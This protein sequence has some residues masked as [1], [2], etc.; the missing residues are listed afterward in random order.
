MLHGSMSQSA[1]SPQS[2]CRDRRGK[3]CSV[4]V[5]SYSTAAVGRRRHKSSFCIRPQDRR[6]PHCLATG[7]RHSRRRSLFVGSTVHCPQTISSPDQ[8]PFGFPCS[9]KPWTHKPGPSQ[10]AWLLASPSWPA[11]PPLA[12]WVE[13]FQA[14]GADSRK[15]G[16]AVHPPLLNKACCRSKDK[17]PSPSHPSSKTSSVGKAW[18]CGS[19]QHS[20]W[21]SYRRNEGAGCRTRCLPT[22]MCTPF[23]S[24]EAG[25]TCD[26]P[27]HMIRR[28][29]AKRS[30]PA[31]FP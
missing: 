7:G 23:L 12:R 13:E 19:G 26:G 1:H 4:H 20:R 15:A 31:R 6:S 24:N 22:G 10:Q 25:R 9:A 14:R 2:S 16:Q 3:T 5:C 8:A 27:Q 17:Q 28:C 30:Q 11:P 18:A 21:A 29:T